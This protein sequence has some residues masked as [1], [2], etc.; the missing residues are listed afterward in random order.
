MK[1]DSK[2]PLLI[3]NSFFQ[4]FPPVELQLCKDQSHELHNSFAESSIIFHI[5]R[6][7]DSRKKLASN[8]ASFN[9]RF[10]STQNILAE[11]TKIIQAFENLS[12][13]VTFISSS[14]D[15]T[16]FKKEICD[17][18]KKLIDEQMQIIN[19]KQ[20][21]ISFVAEFDEIWS[22]FAKLERELIKQKNEFSIFKLKVGREKED[23]ELRLVECH[24][25]VK[26]EKTAV[27]VE[28]MDIEREKHRLYGDRLAFQKKLGVLSIQEQELRVEKE[29]IKADRTSLN[30]LRCA[31]DQQQ[32]QFLA[33]RSFLHHR[34][35]MLERQN[36]DLLD[37]VKTLKSE[38]EQAI[39]DKIACRDLQENLQKE[40]TSNRKALAK[41]RSDYE[42][43]TRRCRGYVD[44]I[45]D[46]SLEL[47]TL[48]RSNFD[49]NKKLVDTENI[50]SSFE[51]FHYTF[52]FLFI[53]IL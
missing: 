50:V 29:K 30:E 38:K 14:V 42:V 46:F 49:L 20:A 7:N 23:E 22:D 16:A 8:F 48:H 36:L 1:I 17:Y 35:Q 28:K 3:K 13:F 18:R 34:I 9:S 19:D 10:N 52:K 21:V 6:S 27:E 53:H 47:G 12:F 51:Y 4:T 40:A 2:I 31:L 41:F 15:L 37:Q 24:E 25:Q 44:D 32:Q 33:E 39:Q 26:K 5:D 11:C 45:N 43:L